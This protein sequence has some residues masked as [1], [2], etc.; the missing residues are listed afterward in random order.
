MTQK[1]T[2]IKI[3]VLL[4]F[5]A[6]ILFVPFS[7]LLSR[8]HWNFEHDYTEVKEIKIG[9]ANS[10]DDY[11]VIKELDLSFAEELLN[12]IESLPERKYV[13][14]PSVTSG[15]C[16]IIVFSNGEYDI[17]TC[18]EPEHVIIEDEKLQGYI[19]WLCYDSEEF[20]S[21]INKY[22]NK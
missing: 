13:W 11:V 19:S 12:D 18:R 16:F 7:C 21:L 15:E 17:I 8:Y 2:K 20:Q 6:I 14:N 22:K 10:Y 4:I 1:K 3:V 9:Y 5:L